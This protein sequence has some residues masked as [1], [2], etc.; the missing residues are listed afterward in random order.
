MAGDDCDVPIAYRDLSL[1]ESPLTPVS[2]GR[3]KRWQ[4]HSMLFSRRGR[5]KHLNTL[6]LI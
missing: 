6:I 2:E 3:R 5:L 1:R 4:S